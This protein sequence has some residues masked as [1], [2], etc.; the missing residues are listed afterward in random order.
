MNMGEKIMVVFQHSP[1]V[2]GDGLFEAIG[3][4]DVRNVV[5]HYRLPVERIGGLGYRLSA[6][7]VREVVG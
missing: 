2:V 5:S 1:G 7:K 4:R 3:I 6:E